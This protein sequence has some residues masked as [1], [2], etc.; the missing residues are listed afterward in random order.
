MNSIDD[1]TITDSPTITNFSVGVWIYINS[2]NFSNSSS[3]ST[4]NIMLLKSSNGNI[5]SLDMNLTSPNLIATI[6]SSEQI[7]LT[8]NFPIQ[9]WVYVII[10]V[11]NNIVDGYLD[12]R[13]VTSYQLSLSNPI[14]LTGVKSLILTFGKNIDVY[15][16]NLE[17]L[18]YPMDPQ[19]AQSKYYSKP[20]STNSMT[21]YNLQFAVTKDGSTYKSFSLF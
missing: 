17:R 7:T 10:S 2:W 6:N 11:S 13:L 15:L 18:T 20:P 9:K 5:L 16:Y 19:S 21:N 8:N 4:Q 14:K 12:G 3:S 1:V